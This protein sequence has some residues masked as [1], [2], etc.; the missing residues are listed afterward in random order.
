[1]YWV[2]A[3]APVS[4]ISPV[5]RK[6]RQIHRAASSSTSPSIDSAEPAGMPARR[7]AAR[8][9]RCRGARRG[10]CERA[11]VAG[12]GEYGPVRTSRC[13]LL[14]RNYRVGFGAPKPLVKALAI[15]DRRADC[16]PSDEELLHLMQDS[17]ACPIALLPA[18]NC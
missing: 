13:C 7:H 10:S 1:M 8:R 2:L 18:G 9:C 4:F 12:A 6:S 16:A 15:P 5:R 11:D 3:W 17:G 14:K